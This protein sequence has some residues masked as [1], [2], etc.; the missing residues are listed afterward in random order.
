M[1]SILWFL[2]AIQIGILIVL[3]MRI[4][5]YYPTNHWGLEVLWLLIL[6]IPSLIIGGIGIAKEQKGKWNFVVGIVLAIVF[7]ASLLCVDYFNIL[8]R[9]EKWL[10]RGMPEIGEM[11]R[12]Y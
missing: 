10:H 3:G 9:Y 6:V 1:K 4:Y 7:G 5:S 11:N 2:S 8:V 12:L